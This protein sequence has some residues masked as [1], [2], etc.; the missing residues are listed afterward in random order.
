LTERGA[1]I[2]FGTAIG[3]AMESLGIPLA[4]G[5]AFGVLMLNAFILTTLDTCARLSRYIVSETIGQRVPILKNMYIA[6]AV[7]LV[8]AYL[9]TL[10]N[11]WRVLWPA[12]GAANQLIAA[13][14]LLVGSAYLF[15]YK[16]PTIY[17][18][19]PG[20]FM[21]ITTEGAL[22]YQLVGQYLPNGNIILSILAVV[23]MSLG[24]VVSWEVYR[25]LR[26]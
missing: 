14:A 15:G 11:N 8:L 4:Y 17:S 21:L 25:R 12:F 9:L 19:L 22:L 3:R 20:I 23:L 1:N 2:T 6:T 24:L 26:T 13:L 16:K 18:L 7:G 5:I 10:G